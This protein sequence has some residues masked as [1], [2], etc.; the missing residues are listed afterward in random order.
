MSK[1]I[2][3]AHA[4]TERG[5]EFMKT[6]VNVEPAGGAFDTMDM[7]PQGRPFNPYINSGAICVAMQL[8]GDM[9]QRFRDFARFIS[10]FCGRQVD[11]DRKI[12]QSESSTAARNRAIGEK[13]L[14]NGICDSE[15]DKQHGLE[16]YFMFCSIMINTVDLA[17]LAATCAHGGR[18]AVTK[19]QACEKEIIEEMM[20]V[21]MTC[22][23]CFVGPSP[24]T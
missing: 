21:M 11:Y 14:E 19:V 18:N 22:G 10:S 17:Q 24:K 9:H 7:D 16:A 20:S 13:L 2:A 1:P 4:I 5:F 12:Y 8:E 3:Y 23:E 15:F 6:K